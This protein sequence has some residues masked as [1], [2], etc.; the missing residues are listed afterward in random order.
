M[1]HGMSGAVAERQVAKCRLVSSIVFLTAFVAGIC[2]E[3]AGSYSQ[4]RDTVRVCFAGDVMLAR[5]VNGMIRKK[6]EAFLFE[7]I[8]PALSRYKYRFI[9]LECPLTPLSY[10]PNKP[11]S[12]RADTGYIGILTAAGITHASLANNHIDDQTVKGAGDTYRVLEKNGIVPLGLKSVKDSICRPAELVLNGR[13]V[14]VFAALGLV[15]GSPNVWYCLD[16]LFL[17]SITAFKHDTPSAFVICYLHWGT[18]YRRFP[19]Q[20]QEEIAGKLT[21]AGADMIIGHHPHVVESIRYYRGRPILFSLGNLIFDQHDRDARRG[22]IAGL[23][24]RDGAVQIDIIPYDIVEDR[25]VPMESG[26][27]LRFK[28]TLLGLSP[29]ISLVDDGDGWTVKETKPRRSRDPDSTGRRIFRRKGIGDSS[30]SPST[31]SRKL[32]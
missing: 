6:G 3:P 23:T 8:R 7:K 11:Y 29:D 10:P 25:P 5:G 28:R 17:K 24:F 21:A 15:M 32:R 4:S 14:A 12:F 18:E 26:E 31:G 16:T 19:S 13:R 1:T 9:N 30:S 20:E 2:M 27:R 22:I